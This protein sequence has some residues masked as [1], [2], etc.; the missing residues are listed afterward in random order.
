VRVRRLLRR[1]STLDSA[2]AVTL[3]LRTDNSECVPRQ[4]LGH[5]GKP[6]DNDFVAR[7]ESVNLST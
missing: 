6:V 2:T 5:L 1:T 3:R 7:P 4:D